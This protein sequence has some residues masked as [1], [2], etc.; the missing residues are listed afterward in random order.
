VGDGKELLE[1]DPILR[2]TVEVIVK[3]TD[4]DRIILFGQGQGE[5]TRRAAITI[6]SCLRRASSQ[7]KEE[8]LELKYASPF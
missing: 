8:K 2:R 5:I 7:G 6:S 3:E 4:P 1:K